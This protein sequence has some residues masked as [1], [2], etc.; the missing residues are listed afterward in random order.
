MLKARF[1]P[2]ITQKMLENRQQK[3]QIR[4]IKRDLESQLRLPAHQQIVEANYGDAS[5]VQKKV[6][7]QSNKSTISQQK[8]DSVKPI[9]INSV[10]DEVFELPKLLGD[11]IQ[12]I[13]SGVALIQENKRTEG[14][15]STTSPSRMS[16]NGYLRQQGEANKRAAL[17]SDLGSQKDEPCVVDEVIAASKASKS[18]FFR[19]KK[20]QKSPERM[21][22]PPGSSEQDV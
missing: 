3:E 17:S 2:P 4:S 19:H 20:S 11:G 6:E 10:N 7:K 5:R 14:P 12:N 13:A 21:I 1:K 22:Y 18:F 8:E 9:D 15:K 16:L